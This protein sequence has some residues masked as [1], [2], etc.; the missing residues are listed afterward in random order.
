MGTNGDEISVAMNHY[1]EHPY[2]KSKR[3]MITVHQNNAK[4]ADDYRDV[5]FKLKITG[6]PLLVTIIRISNCKLIQIDLILSQFY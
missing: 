2:D 4:N 3:H 5:D 6:K 1:L